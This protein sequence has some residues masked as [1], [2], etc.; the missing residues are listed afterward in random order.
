MDAERIR[1]LFAP[2]GP[3]TVRRMFGGAGIYRDGVIFALEVDGELYLKVDET[4]RVAFVQAGSR[5]FTYDGKGKPVTM[6]Y[7]L[8]PEAAHEDPEELERWAR[9]ALSAAARAR[10]SRRKS[11]ATFE[12]R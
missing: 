9:L 2:V 11:Q 10:P 8:L 12:N 4:S 3:V 6:P 1:E 7:W 5:P